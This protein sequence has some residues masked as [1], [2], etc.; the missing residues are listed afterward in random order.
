[1]RR[2]LW[3]TVVK[4]LT[5][6]RRDRAGL[7][8]LLVM[9]V[10]LVIVV[11]LVQDSAMRATGMAS[12]R[13]LFVDEDRGRVGE[14]VSAL[15]VPARG[16]ELI[17]Q[18]HGS[19][20]S[21]ADARAA[22]A[23]GDEQFFVHVAPGTT[24]AL[25][26]QVERRA[27]AR[28]GRGAVGDRT[29]ASVGAVSDGPRT[30]VESSAT[31]AAGVARG[32]VTV[33]F[34]PAVQEALRTTVL[35]VVERVALAV[36]VREQEAAL[37]RLIAWQMAAVFGAGGLVGGAPP[38]GA[39]GTTA[40]RPGSGSGPASAALPE[41]ALAVTEA[42][43]LHGPAP[44]RPTSA[45]QNVPAWALFGMF[46]TVVPLSGSLVRERLSGT[47]RRLLALP[48]SPLGLA[49]GKVCAYVTV[50]LG[51]F[52]LMLLVG[53]AVLPR[54]GATGLTVPPPQWPAVAVIALAAALAATGYGLMVGALARS[55]EQA[56]MFGAVSVV[57]AA[58]LGG[59]MVPVVAMPRVMQTLSVVS[60]L[61]W[62][63]T[64]FQD[65]FVRNGTIRAAAPEALALT[66]FAAGTIGVASWALRGRRV[67]G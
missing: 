26:A 63:L 22:L 43:A 39:S 38:S 31:G 5:E 27:M 35:S 13:V 58:A 1:M 48:I 46:F 19:A 40:P 66:A 37:S 23:R 62:G 42:S 60:P 54:F 12:I 21:A 57:I 29:A 16:I 24:A 14:M 18:R 6:L 67:A 56:S 15:L 3:A 11:A 10:V 65:I 50:C 61:A 7:L 25:A 59:I 47:L 32:G 2:T 53:W 36:E 30:A 44:V 28:F 17:T 20:L 8:V 34:D 64:G 45:Q 41:S 33:Y 51:Q 55:Q 49:V 52:V 4:D 9:P